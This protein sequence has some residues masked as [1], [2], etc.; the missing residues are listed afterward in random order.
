MN[1]IPLQHKEEPDETKSDW[2]PGLAGQSRNAV[3]RKKFNTRKK[4]CLNGRNGCPDAQHSRFW[5][6]EFLL[7]NQSSNS[8]KLHTT[9]SKEK[10]LLIVSALVG[11]VLSSCCPICIWILLLPPSL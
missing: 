10:T 8:A 6:D 3:S 5:R 2:D 11:R 7:P 9:P 4:F 1:Q